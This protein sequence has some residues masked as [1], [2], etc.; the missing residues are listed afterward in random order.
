M[1]QPGNIIRFGVGVKLGAVVF[2]LASVAI[3]LLAM[4][5]AEKN[6]A[7]AFAQKEVVGAQ[8]L[9][10]LSQLSQQ[11]YQGRMKPKDLALQQEIYK[12]LQRL[13]SIFPQHQDALAITAERRVFQNLAQRLSQQSIEVVSLYPE[14]IQAVSQLNRRVGDTSNLI[15]DPDLD[16]YYLMD[17]MLLRLPEEQALLSEMLVE[18]KEP[19]GAVVWREKLRMQLGLLRES[20][21]SQRHSLQTAYENNPAGNLTQATRERFGGKVRQQ[22]AYLDTLSLYLAAPDPILRAQ[23]FEQGAQSLAVSFR[24][25]EE[26]S[27]LLERLLEVRIEGFERRKWGTLAV[28]ALVLVTAM[29]FSILLTQ[30]IGRTLRKVSLRLEALRA[31]DITR[32]EKGIVALAEGR[33]DI[34]LEAAT[35]RRRPLEVKS[36]DELGRLARSV[37]QLSGQAQVTIEALVTTRDTLARAE[38]ALRESE[39]QMRHQAFHDTL[40]GLPNRAYLLQQLTQATDRAQKNQTTV[41]LLFLDLDN[42][43][44]VNDSWGHEVGDLLLKAIV[45]RLLAHARP[46]DTIARLGGDEFLVL[47]EDL[48]SDETALTL[49]DQFCRALE[50]P[51][52]LQGQELFSSFSLGIA[53]S[54]QGDVSAL[55]LVK[56]AD[57]A[58]YRA[59]KRGKA[60]YIAFDPEMNELARS[61]MELESELRQALSRD[62]ELCLYFQPIYRLCDNAFCEVEAL[63]RWNHPRHGLTSPDRF[64]ALAEETGLIVPMGKWILHTACQQAKA[65][66]FP[67]GVNLSLRQLQH[68]DFV[69]LMKQVL[70]ETGVSPGLI[71]LEVTETLMVENPKKTI[72]LLHKLKE[73]GVRL[74]LDDFGVGYSS[75]THL[76]DMPIDTLKIDRSFVKRLG[77]STEDEAIVAAMVHLAKSLHLTIVCEGIETKS[78][79]DCLEFLSCDYGQ[80]FLYARPQKPREIT[81]LLELIRTRR[82]AA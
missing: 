53:F 18:L 43:K 11:V 74:A 23:L 73:L 69:G 35:K 33:H 50:E 67:V 82:Q 56:H 62:D 24:F 29:G 75:M 55:D 15:L 54:R 7:I 13:E 4:L 20:L 80:G 52:V 8:F 72:A 32:L 6:I 22:E 78:Q 40:T 77:E 61:R 48:N 38:E 19:S 70:L 39:R 44:V 45:Q 34:A 76:R 59:K 65:W 49:A 21:A 51:L 10:P 3:L 57:I 71:R 31:G 46:G 2:A 12:R 14:L 64:I 63:V 30:H 68:E 36:K 47:I 79:E 60:H 5:F 81:Q 41:A 17:L 16:S 28:V 58:M 42:F 37:N 1:P 25:S 26:T 66:N 9:R 27:Q